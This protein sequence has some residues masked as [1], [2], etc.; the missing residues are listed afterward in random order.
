MRRATSV[1]NSGALGRPHR[2]IQSF[3]NIARMKSVRL[4]LFSVGCIGLGGCM[5]HTV[6][7]GQRV[8]SPDKN[9]VLG[10]SAHGASGRAFSALTKKRVYVWIATTVKYNDYQM[11]TNASIN[12]LDKK[13]VFVAADLGSHVEWHGS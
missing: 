11:P 13:Y 4:F 7:G 5:M 3:G 10:S 12:L 8:Y 1:A 6:V 2:S 9:Y